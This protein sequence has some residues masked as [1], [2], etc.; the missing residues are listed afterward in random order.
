MRGERTVARK[1]EKGV[2]RICKL[3]RAAQHLVRD[4]GEADDLGRKPALGVD[5]GLERF[6]D[7]AVFENN[8]ADLGDGVARNL[9]AGRFNVE[10]A[11]LARKIA[12]LRSVYSNAVVDI[13]EKIA[14]AAVKDFN[15]TLAGMP[16]VREA[17]C[18][19]VVGNGDGGHSPLDRALDGGGRV[20]QRVHVGH[21]RVQMQ[22]H[23]L[24]L[25]RVLALLVLDL[26]DVLRV[27]LHILAIE[28]KLHA[29]ADAQPH[30]VGDLAV[31]LDRLALRKTPADDERALVVRHLK[32]HRPHARAARFVAIELEDFALDNDV[33]GLGRQLA[34]GK[35]S[36]LCDLA[37]HDDAAAAAHLAAR[38]FHHIGKSLRRGFDVNV[39]AL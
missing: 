29:P 23:A 11:D 33:A 27:E 35:H 5:K 26:H 22:L 10:A 4:A 13:V 39:H 7:F 31:Q 36:P 2:Q 1:V 9:E 18:H 12:V 17:L 25:R 19:T 3:R 14:L 8:G 16:G 24:F 30:A 32:Q 20:G 38:V 34:D 6:D 37:S 15:F 21:A 28:G